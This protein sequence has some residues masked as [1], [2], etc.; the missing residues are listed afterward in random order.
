MARALNLLAIKVLTRDSLRP[1]TTGEALAEKRARQKKQAV[2]RGKTRRRNMLQPFVARWNDQQRE[3]IIEEVSTLTDKYQ[4]TVP[5][6]IRRI[7]RVNKRDQ[8]TYRV[9]PYGEV[10]LVRRAKEDEHT[11][12]VVAGFLD[13]LERGMATQRESVRPATAALRDRAFALT[14]GIEYDINAL[15]EDD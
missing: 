15:L 14:A 7:L 10:V 11:D 3:V 2:E 5:E 12:S 6:P 8:L 13:L 9:N 1:T 4:T